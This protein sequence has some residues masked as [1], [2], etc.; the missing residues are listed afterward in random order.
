MRLALCA[1]LLASMMGCATAQSNTWA[2]DGYTKESNEIG[3]LVAAKKISRSEGNAEILTIARAY[4]PND[5]RLANHWIYATDLAIK[6]EAGELSYEKF[7]AQINASWN[8]YHDISDKIRQDQQAAI[9]Q[10]QNSQFIGNFLGSMG[11]RM[12]RTYPQPI[13][14]SSTSMPGVVTTNC[15]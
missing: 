3:A 4:F 14:C 12:N 15:R 6:L 8:R 9:D 7:A 11:N 10:Q 2:T 13:T 1:F 5:I